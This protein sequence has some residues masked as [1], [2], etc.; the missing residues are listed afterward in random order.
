LIR[1]SW[2][3]SNSKGDRGQVR[4]HPIQRGLEGIHPSLESFLQPI[5]P[6]LDGLVMAIVASNFPFPNQART[7]PTAPTTKA[8]M[9][10]PARSMFDPILS[11]EEPPQASTRV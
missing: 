8:L 4:P 2:A 10:F 5:D 9:A 11:G 1:G 3:R 7:T 6:V